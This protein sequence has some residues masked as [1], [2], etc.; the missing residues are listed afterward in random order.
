MLMIFIW[1][2]LITN[3]GAQYLGDNV[4]SIPFVGPNVDLEI[5]VYVQT[6]GTYDIVETTQETVY[7]QNGHYYII[8]A[9]GAEIGDM[10]IEVGVNDGVFE[11]IQKVEDA[12]L[13]QSHVYKHTQVEGLDIVEIYYPISQRTQLKTRYSYTLA[14]DMVKYQDVADINRKFVAGIPD[15]SEVELEIHLPEDVSQHE[16]FG[17]WIHGFTAHKSKPVISQNDDGTM[18][19]GYD[20]PYNPADEFIEVRMMIPSDVISG[21]NTTVNS[22]GKPT[23]ISE[24]A[25]ITKEINKARYRELGI[26]LVLLVAGVFFFIKKLQESFKRRTRWIETADR[27]PEHIHTRP[28]D[29]LALEVKR[30]YGGAS[31]IEVDD[32]IS[33]ILSLAHKGYIKV[34]LE[35]GSDM[36]TLVKLNNTSLPPMDSYERIF[37]E[38]VLIA[39][40][41]TIDEV[42]AVIEAEVKGKSKGLLRDM[43]NYLKSHTNVAKPYTPYK[44]VLYVIAFNIMYLTALIVGFTGTLPLISGTTILVLVAMIIIITTVDTI[45]SDYAL[46]DKDEDIIEAQKWS[47]YVNMIETIGQFERRVVHENILWGQVFV[48]AASFGLLDTVEKQL[49]FELPSTAQIDKRTLTQLARKRGRMTKKINRIQRVNGGGSSSGSRGGSR[50]SSGGSG[51]GSSRGRF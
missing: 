25:N 45:F 31:N 50:S 30:R 28:T 24:E 41:T 17:T 7:K 4:D 3:G 29:N 20:I 6:D 34:D 13:G 23:I 1:V 48:D 46:Y 49:N 22:E 2:A 35:P 32:I 21:L 12:E 39:E 11:P 42:E 37:T 15:L 5:D 10:V 9:R 18:T 8:D 26:Y 44:E 33:I 40:T 36:V 47:A 14:G 51:G 43:T 19:V 16:L 27:V 38:R